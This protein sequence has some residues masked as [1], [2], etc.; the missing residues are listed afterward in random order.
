MRA[1]GP[2]ECVDGLIGQAFDVRWLVGV[3]ADTYGGSAV[4]H[5]AASRTAR[6]TTL[7]GE[8][9]HHLHAH[10]GGCLRRAVPTIPCALRHAARCSTPRPGEEQ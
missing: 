7:Q 5:G 1:K 4:E 2:A 3:G 8:D 6:S 10:G 9:R